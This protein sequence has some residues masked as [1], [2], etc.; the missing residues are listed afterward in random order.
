MIPNLPSHAATCGHS[1]INEHW[2]IVRPG[3]TVLR[4]QGETVALA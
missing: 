2:I 4:E 3:M 1:P